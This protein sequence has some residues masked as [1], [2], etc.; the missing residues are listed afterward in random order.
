MK[1]PRFLCGLRRLAASCRVLALLGSAAWLTSAA[2]AADLSEAELLRAELE[3]MK[4]AHAEQMRR[5]EERIQALEKPSAPAS[6]ST[7]AAA[8][9]PAPQAVTPVAEAPAPARDADQ[10]GRALAEKEFQRT[11]EARDQALLSGEH[12]FAGRMEEVL[13]GYMDIHGYFRAG[14]GRN[15]GGGSMVGFQAPGAFSKYRLGNEADSYGEIT[16]GKNFYGADA[17]ARDK[18]GS[19]AAASA[20][21]IGRFQTTIAAFTPIQDAVSSGS[22]SFSFADIWGSVGNVVSSQPSLKFWAG[23]RYYRRHDIHLSDFFFSNMS[24]TGG[25]F[26][27]YTLGNGKLALAWI[28][29]PGSSGVSSAPEPDAANKAGY[30]K[31]NLDLRLYDVDV[32]GGKG[33]FG[34]VYAR[35]TSGL[36]SS[37]NQAPESS[38]ISGMFIHT[39]QGVFSA[40][41]VNKASIQFGTGAAKTLN[42]GFETFSLNG[43]SF[44][45]ADERDSWRLRITENFTANLSDSF[46]FGPV[47]VY[48]LTDYAGDEGKVQWV[49]AGMRPIW[50][51]DSHLSLAF[52]AG[53][54][55]VKDD[56]AG[57]S[58]ALYKFTLAPQVSLGGRFMSRPVVRAFVTYAKWGDDFI[59]R[60][61]GQDFSGETDGLTGGMHM[62]VWW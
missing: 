9:G 40:D 16:F 47:F 39:R 57:T 22:A 15:S 35:A 55:W 6:A 13:Q 36:D 52:E 23:N 43:Q 4:K 1:I 7:T 29:Q 44:I 30:S 2:L 11:T 8:A 46:S 60:I 41:G 53:L 56:L 12:P 42:S 45:R 25:G 18:P 62:E 19:A 26:E 28:G 33:E 48:Q 38:G 59:G 20:G 27:D 3:A 24:G 21:P 54:D 58:D 61:G 34:L 51:F 14:Y 5:L 17:F 49:S 10:A 37:G 50:H 32:P 31:T